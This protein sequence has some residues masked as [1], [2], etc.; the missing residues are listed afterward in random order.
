[1]DYTLEEIEQRIY[2]L[3]RAVH[4]ERPSTRLDPTIGPLGALWAQFD[5]LVATNE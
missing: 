5:R 3:Y 1:M 2:D 4:T